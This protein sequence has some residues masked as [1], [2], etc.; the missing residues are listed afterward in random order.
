MQKKISIKFNRSLQQLLTLSLVLT[1]SAIS[2]SCTSEPKNNSPVNPPATQSPDATVSKTLEVAVV[3][4]QSPEKQQKKIQPLSDYLQKTI[5]RSVHFQVTKD[6][7]TAV[8]LLVEEKVDMAY[9]G[10]SSYL[11]ARERN[12]NLEPLVLPINKATGRPWYTS[13]IVAD[14]N[15]GINSLQDLKGK[16]FAFV[17]PSST[18]VFLMPMNSLQKEGIDPIQDFEKIV[19]TGSHDTTETALANGEVDAI[20]DDKN[21]FERAKN[22]GKLPAE[23]YEIIWE[24]E[25]I[26]TGQI[27]INSSKFNPEEIDK[28]KQALI[29]AP[30]GL[31]DVSGFESAGYTLTKDADFAEIRQIFNRVKSVR[32][33]EK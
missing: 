4:W 33:P 9:L 2:P 18:S 10:A 6:Y 13:V 26:T 28:L 15:Q 12:V 30:I 17:S 23:N 11:E 5:N 3:P 29:D 7:K 27:V 31:L 22:A 21:S 24:S 16:R 20:A 25:P 8:N 32:I 1:A 19:Y 14:V